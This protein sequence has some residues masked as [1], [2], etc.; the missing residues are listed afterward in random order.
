MK[1]K[2]IVMAGGWTWWHV[3]PIKS[4]IE[5]I[6]SEE[7]YKEKVKQ[8]IRFWSKNSLEQETAKR[9]WNNVKFISILSGKYRRETPLKAHLKNI[10][11][12]FLFVAW[13]FQAVFYLIKV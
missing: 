10:R 6:L 13:C 4:L 1:Q 7:E 3:F 11:D 8:I 5:T 2:T 9:F 12:A